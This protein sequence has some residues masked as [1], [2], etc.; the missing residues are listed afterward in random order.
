M[1]FKTIDGLRVGYTL[2]YS[3]PTAVQM[4]RAF[5]RFTQKYLK[6]I[7]FFIIVGALVWTNVLT[8]KALVEASHLGEYCAVFASN[9]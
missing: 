3:S 9:Y 6:T 8:L 1:R 4:W 7:L 2:D 5:E